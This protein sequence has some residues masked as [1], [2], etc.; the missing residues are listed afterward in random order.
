MQSPVALY[1]TLGFM[2]VR[3][4]A[5]VARSALSIARKGTCNNATQTVTKLTSGQ[6]LS[7][8]TTTP[9]MHALAGAATSLALVL[10][11]KAHSHTST[12]LN[13]R[14]CDTQLAQ[15]QPER[16]LGKVHKTRQHTYCMHSYQSSLATQIKQH[17]QC[18]MQ[19]AAWQT[20]LAVQTQLKS[21]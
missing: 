9:S 11:N 19:T 1:D 10:C 14:A 12:A 21:K 18:P 8:Q 6:S 16:A 3:A 4:C 15:I 7:K 5:H 20:S 13:Q 2:S 17:G